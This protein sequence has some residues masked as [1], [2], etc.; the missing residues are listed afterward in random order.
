MPPR[1]YVYALPHVVQP[2][3]MAGG[4]VV[5]IDVLRAATTLCHAL[6]AGV[7][8][9]VPCVEIEEAQ[10]AAASVSGNVVLGGERE[11]LPVEGF[12]LGNSPSEYTPDRV[13]GKTLVFTTSNGT[14]AL[15]HARLADRVLL[16]AFVNASAV[17]REL[18]GREQVHILCSGTHG[19]YSED[20]VLLAGMLVERLERTG[21]FNYAQNAQ[22]VTAREFWLNSFPLPKAVGAEPLEPELLVPKLRQSA[23]GRNLVAVGL[24]GDL[25][26]A[27]QMDRFECVPVYDAASGRIRAV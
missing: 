14:R 19:Q 12:D 24:E 16:G 5:V 8:E 9:V 20:D 10:A 4:T 22:A 17:V 15:H 13:G 6:E 1:L 27:A 18:L 25:I 2:E 11:G 3:E 21:G 7:A 26:D 23:G